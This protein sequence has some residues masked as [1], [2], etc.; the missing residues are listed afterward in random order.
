MTIQ[1]I[2]K[3]S[4]KIDQPINYNTEEFEQKLE[5]KIKNIFTTLYYHPEIIINVKEFDDMIKPHIS[6]L[7]KNITNLYQNIKNHNIKAK[8]NQDFD[9]QEQQAARKK[10][11]KIKFEEKITNKN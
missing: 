6:N 5:Q 2:N 7:P 9:K 1:G 3:E 10:L 11:Y 4:K 8:Q